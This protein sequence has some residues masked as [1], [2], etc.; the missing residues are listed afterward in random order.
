MT[1]ERIIRLINVMI[2]GHAY[3]AEEFA[4]EGDENN[5]NERLAAAS[6]L[7]DLLERIA[8]ARPRIAA[9]V[10]TNLWAQLVGQND[11]WGIDWEQYAPVQ[12]QRAQNGLSLRLVCYSDVFAISL[13]A[14][15]PTQAEKRSALEWLASRAY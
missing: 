11:N 1:V 6:A 8:A 7:E 14:H 15:K 13:G 9:P 5:Q 3:H 4:L 2:L 12:V 10:D